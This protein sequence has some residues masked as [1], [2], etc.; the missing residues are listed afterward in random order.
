LHVAK[1]V[2]F[3]RDRVNTDSSTAVAST[4]F[5]LAEATTLINMTL[6]YNAAKIAQMMALP[7]NGWAVIH[8]TF[9]RPT[10][11]SISEWKKG[12]GEKWTR[13][14]EHGDKCA[15]S[16]EAGPPFRF[17]AGQ[18]SGPCRAGVKR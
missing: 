13:L 3:L 14:I 11:F 7:G 8:A 2:A 4:F 15:Y 9:D 5:S 12:N 10:G 6:N 18:C 1:S 17:M 16:G